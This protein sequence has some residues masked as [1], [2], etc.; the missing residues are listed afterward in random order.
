MAVTLLI[1]F[2]STYTK[3]RAVDLE[4]EEIIGSS[5]A[6][7]TVETDMTIGLQSVEFIAELPRNPAGK[8]LK[9]MLREKYG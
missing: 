1:D 5:Q 3:I 7:S 8:V 2:G 4:K 9:K 6:P